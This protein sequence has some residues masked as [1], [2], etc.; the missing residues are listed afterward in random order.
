M[1][2]YVLQPQNKFHSMDAR[3]DKETDTI[4][5]YIKISSTMAECIFDC[6]EKMAKLAIESGVDRCTMANICKKV[7]EEWGH[8]NLMYSTDM[9]H[10]E[11]RNAF[12][13]RTRFVWE[14]IGFR[15]NEVALQETISVNDMTLGA[16]RSLR[17]IAKKRSRLEM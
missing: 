7:D 6:Y 13:T 5:S 8:S 9:T 3:K 15:V 14:H 10:E 16:I 17:S 11:R 4:D 1:K 2:H 12:V